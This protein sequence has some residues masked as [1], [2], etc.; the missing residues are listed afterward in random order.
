MTGNEFGKG[1]TINQGDIHYYLPHGPAPARSTARVIP[2]PHNRDFIRRPDL[3]DK[4][5][6]LLP[7][8]EH[9]KS[10]ALWGLGGAGY[11]FTL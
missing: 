10:A 11:T 2:Y 6:E 3:V 8:G 4:L 1:T 7:L 9:Y 5:N